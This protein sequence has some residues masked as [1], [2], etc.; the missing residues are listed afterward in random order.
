MNP[1]T[2]ANR[3]A[4]GMS[5]AEAISTPVRPRKPTY[6]HSALRDDARGLVLQRMNDVRKS[7]ACIHAKGPLRVGDT[8]ARAKLKRLRSELTFLKSLFG[9]GT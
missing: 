8:Q 2:L 1:R 6:V 7:L 5:Y 3:I 4:G 9:E